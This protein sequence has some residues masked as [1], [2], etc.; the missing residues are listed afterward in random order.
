MTPRALVVDDDAGTRFMLRDALTTAGFAV[1]EAPDGLA[2]LERIATGGYHLVLT[3]LRMPR[4]DGLGLLR[5]LQG[6]PGAPRVV[7]ITAH[8]SE[9]HVVDAL[10]LGA[11]DYLRKPCP[12]AELMAVVARATE[13]A[14]LRLE[15]ERLAGELTLSNGVV[16]RSPQMADLAV[17]VTRAARRNVT[18]LIT[19]ESGTG[20]E[21]I[22]E[23]LVAGSPRAAQPF[24]RFNCAALTPE[25]AEAELFGH[26]KG[27]FTG[28]QR[29]RPGLFR[30]AHQG[31][32]L[33]D[34][35]GELHPALQAKLL[36]V[37]QEGEVRPVGE[38]RS[39]RVDVRVLA[40]THRDLASMVASGAFRQDLFFRL[41][42]VRL[43]V[44]PL[45]E[46]PEDIRV[47]AEHFIVRFARQF[48]AG[49]LRPTAELLDVLAARSW[50]GNVRELENTVERMVALSDGE[51][52]D[53]RLVDGGA[54]PTA[55]PPSGLRAQVNAFE[56]R[57]LV[58]AMAEARGNQAEAARL[59]RIG[60]ATMHDKL[61]KHGLSD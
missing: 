41:N 58:E 2:A 51:T 44:P 22:A 12:I 1:D 40:S 20:K 26:S 17:L 53:L 24:V 27:A 30:E 42:V 55:P 36:R 29:A 43:H 9:Q 25:L 11:F 3:D 32:L 45:R 6:M 19:G 39:V 56:R 10:R 8:G 33:L 57:L 50:P 38:E 34:E 49:S 47:L 60:R 54:A 35:I 37:L 61:R 31:T 16:L 28:A 48:D 18:V 13:T 14:R 5:R 59:L 23:A 52:L 46:R 21:R 7:L 15:N 4:L